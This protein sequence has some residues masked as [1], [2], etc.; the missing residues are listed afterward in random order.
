MSLVTFIGPRPNLLGI[1]VRPMPP[2]RLEAQQPI[3]TADEMEKI[4]HVELFTGGA[5]R[6]RRARH[7]LSRGVGRERHGGRAREPLRARR[8]RD[9]P[10]LQHPDRVRPQG[11]GRADADP[12]AARDGGRAPASGAQ[13]LAHQHRASSS[14]PARRAK[15]I[16]SRCSRATAR[17]RSIRIS[18]SKRSR[19]CAESV[20]GRLAA[21]SR[22]SASSRRSARGSYKVMS[23]MG[24]STYQS[25]CGAQI[26]EAVGLQ[27]AFVDK[28]FTGT[29]S[30]VEGIG[31]FEVAEEAYAAAPARVRRRSAAA[32]RARRRR[33]VSVPRA[34]RRAHVDA[35]LDRQAA[36]RGARRTA[37]RRT[38][39]TRR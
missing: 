38:R 2:M 6:S 20:P 8:G 17:R 11:V 39:N 21:R 23:K 31:L 27:R 1:D 9:P 34:R 4:R 15:C 33:R 19:S 18:R 5:F 28:Y 10:G 22:R 30:N 29:A 25:Y 35:G 36:A 3:L 12:G 24:I 14:R 26:F 32:R 13:G 37:T 16:T 7:L